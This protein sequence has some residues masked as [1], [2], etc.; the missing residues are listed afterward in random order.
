MYRLLIRWCCA[1]CIASRP[2]ATERLTR[3]SDDVLRFSFFSWCGARSEVQGHAGQGDAEG[4]AAVAG[5]VHRL[6]CVCWMGCLASMEEG[7]LFVVQWWREDL[8][9][10]I[11]LGCLCN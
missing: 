5:E 11:L 8:L 6:S 9:G 1:S 4:E 7:G 2:F 3:V 10:M